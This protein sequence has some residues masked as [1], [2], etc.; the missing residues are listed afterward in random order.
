M[1]YDTNLRKKEQFC[2]ALYIGRIEAYIYHKS[3]SDK[4][5]SLS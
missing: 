3:L 4:R 2:N 5:L 1:G